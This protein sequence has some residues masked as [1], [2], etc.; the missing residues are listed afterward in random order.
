MWSLCDLH[1]VFRMPHGTGAH[2]GTPQ[3]SALRCTPR[4]TSHSQGQSTTT[5]SL[6][7][8]PQQ[9]HPAVDSK[10]TLVLSE[11]RSLASEVS[12]LRAHVDAHHPASTTPD[13]SEWVPGFTTF[14]AI[15]LQKH[16]SASPGML[17]YMQTIRDIA[18]Q[19]GGVTFIVWRDIQVHAPNINCALGW[20]SSRTLYESHHATPLN[21]LQPQSVLLWRRSGTLFQFPMRILHQLP[22]GKFLR[23]LPLQTCMLHLRGGGTLSATVP[24]TCSRHNP[25]RHC[26]DLSTPEKSDRLSHWLVRYPHCSALVQLFHTGFSIKASELTRTGI[27]D[28]WHSNAFLRYIR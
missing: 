4:S 19:G 28:H 25:S 20:C 10:L 21:H 8:W 7:T 11:V 2:R 17:T 22:L 12:S 15:Y 9:P 24:T 14:T 3:P 18:Q 16:P 27:A 26:P 23:G 5:P 13:E 1:Y 6:D